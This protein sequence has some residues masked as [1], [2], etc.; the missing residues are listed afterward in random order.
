MTAKEFDYWLAHFLQQE[1]TR[2]KSL[3]VTILGDSVAPHGGAIWLGSL[4]ALLRTFGVAER[5]VRTSVFRLVQEGWLEAT[6]HGRRSQYRVSSAGRVR[7]AHADRRI[8]EPPAQR[9]DGRWTMVLTATGS[10]TQA[11]RSELKRDLLW[12]GYVALAPGLF[13]RPGGTL[14][15][16]LETLESLAVRERVAIFDACAS[17]VVQG[18]SD[19]ELVR[20]NWPLDSLAKR[21]EAFVTR[22]APVH[23]A[24]PS[25]LDPPRAFQLRTLLIHSYRRVVLH[26][27]QLP[28]VLLPSD[29]PGH[30]AFAM[31][32]LLYRQAI[33]AAEQHFLESAELERDQGPAIPQLSMRFAS[34]APSHNGPLL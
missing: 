19:A 5:L 2:A 29:W 1:P 25:D 10:W 27:P 20:L 4:I 7:I 23:D 11:L 8:Y 16:L 31:C 15:A 17:S 28:A 33:S 12:E 30:R 21:Y 26:D 32:G 14:A 18:Q 3:L 6:R 9:W 13:G 24:D 22:F 34:A